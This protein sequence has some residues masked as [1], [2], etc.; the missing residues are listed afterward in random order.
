MVSDF[1]GCRVGSTSGCEGEWPKVL[2]EFKDESD[3]NTNCP[4]GLSGDDCAPW[5]DLGWTWS[6]PAIARIAKYNASDPQDPDEVFVAFF[7][8]GWDETETDSTGLHFYGIDL[9]TGAVLVKE[10]IGV[11]LPGGVTAL[12][13]D[14]DGFHDR[15]Y[16]A[17]SNGRIYRYQYYSPTNVLQTG[18]TSYTDT[19]LF[20][21]R[22]DF[23]DRQE[24]FTR[25]VPVPVTFDG[26][27]V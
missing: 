21:F 8:G 26:W 27:I 17:D 3:A 24:F 9:A 20:D 15:I 14:V 13:S 6:K 16:F 22:S 2:W 7:G 4:G 23:T 1:A 12:D 18:A 11:D 10:N 5:W 19:V 25:P